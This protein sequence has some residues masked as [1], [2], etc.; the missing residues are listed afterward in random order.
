MLWQIRTPVR[1]SGKVA[2][3]GNCSDIVSLNGSVRSNYS[4]SA[5]TSEDKAGRGYCLKKATA[6]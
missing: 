5:Q 6:L 1:G 4:R 3:L 2:V